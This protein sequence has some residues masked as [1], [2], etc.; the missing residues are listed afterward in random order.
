M[1]SGDAVASRCQV[2]LKRKLKPHG[3]SG[4]VVLSATKVI[5][6]KIGLSKVSINISQTKIKWTKIALLFWLY[7]LDRSFQT[8][9]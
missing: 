3:I 7:K 5:Y 2:V 9:Q 1:V 4:R 8:S 6:A